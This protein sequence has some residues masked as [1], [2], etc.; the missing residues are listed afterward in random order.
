MDFFEEW[1][2]HKKDVRNEMMF[3]FVST[4]H[5]FTDVTDHSLRET[6][7]TIARISAKISSK[8][9]SNGRSQKRFLDQCSDWLSGDDILF[10]VYVDPQIPSTSTEITSG[11][12]GRPQ[13]NCP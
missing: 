1:V 12:P 6:R 9:E 8:W 11:G 10:E 7:L 13:K 2:K 3:R 4:K 5:D